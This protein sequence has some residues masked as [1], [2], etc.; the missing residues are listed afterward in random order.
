MP[1]TPARHPDH[2]PTHIAPRIAFPI[3][4][5]RRLVHQLVERG[6]DII[7]KLDLGHGSH[8]LRGAPDGEPHYPLLAQG[9]VEHALGPEFGGQVHAAAEDAAKGDIFAEEEDALVGAE[10]ASEGA[11]DSLEEVLPGCGNRF[12]ELRQGGMERGGRVVEKWVGGVFDGEIEACVW[13]VG[14]E[15]ALEFGG[16][17]LCGGA[18]G[19]EG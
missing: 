2:Q 11:V 19:G 6:I 9:R 13:W 3:P 8:P 7:R 16:D 15:F 18:D 4:P 1:H 10:G 12:R 14:C 17:V 5:L